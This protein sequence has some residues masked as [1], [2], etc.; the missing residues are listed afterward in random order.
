MCWWKYVPS[1]VRVYNIPALGRVEGGTAGVCECV[2]RMM[3]VSIGWFSG[4]CSLLSSYILTY[5]R[6]YLRFPGSEKHRMDGSQDIHWN[7]EMKCNNKIQTTAHRLWSSAG[8]TAVFPFAWWR[9]R[10]DSTLVNRQTALDPVIL[11][12]QP[13]ELN[14]GQS[15]LLPK[16]TF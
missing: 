6:E 2:G 11:L 1:Y 9:H 13:A 5:L 15:H 3:S 16:I 10:F 4:R 12:A 14:T 8:S 7:G